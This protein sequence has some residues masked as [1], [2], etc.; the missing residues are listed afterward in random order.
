M[1]VDLQKEFRTLRLL[2]SALLIIGAG[3]CI[4]GFGLALMTRDTSKPGRVAP[5]ETKA[6]DGSG[7]E[8]VEAPPPPRPAPRNK[9]DMEEKLGTYWSKMGFN[10]GLLGVLFVGLGLGLRW[11]IRNNLEDD[12][13]VQMSDEL[14]KAYADQLVLAEKQKQKN[15]KKMRL[16]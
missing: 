11:I 7:N 13:E 14:F 12:D 6:A 9:K 4:G 3:L 16:E 1:A 5:S 8:V 10:T 15:R 2:S